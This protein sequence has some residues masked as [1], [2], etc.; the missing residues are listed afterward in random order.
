[1]TF[2]NHS[3]KVHH[4]QIAAIAYE[5]K[6]WCLTLQQVSYKGC[7]DTVMI[8]GNTIW[9]LELICNS[10]TGDIKQS[11]YGVL[12]YTN[13]VAGGEYQRDP[14]WGWERGYLR[15]AGRLLRINLCQP[16]TD[17]NTIETRLDCLEELLINQ[18][19]FHAL[20]ASLKALPDMDPIV[21]HLIKIPKRSDTIMAFQQD[22]STV[23]KMNQVLDY[24]PQ[25]AAVRPPPYALLT[26]P[27]TSA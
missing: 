27:L 5:H 10:R 2:C 23:L 17:K 6:R 1:M 14:N 22:L 20:N 16:P 13:T 26:W 8:D 25:I 3:L 21:S 24:A 4:V 9:N 11:L 19:N 15:R 12:N 7:E 18:E